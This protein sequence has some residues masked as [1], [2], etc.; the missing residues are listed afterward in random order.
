MVGWHHL[1]HGYE[2]EQAVGAGD[3]QGSLACCSPWGCKKSD[4]TEQLNKLIYIYTHT[5]IHIYICSKEN[6]YLWSAFSLYWH[7][8][9]W[10]SRTASVSKSNFMVPGFLKNA[11]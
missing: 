5:Y 3:G 10:H 11:P 8:R 1:L 6:L 2:F 7:S 9:T 4:T